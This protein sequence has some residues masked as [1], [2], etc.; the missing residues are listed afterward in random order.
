MDPCERII[1]EALTSGDHTVGLRRVTCNAAVVQQISCTCG[2]ILDQHT[3]VVIETPDERV[4]AA[5]CPDCRRQAKRLW[6]GHTA[7]TWDSS[8]PL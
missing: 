1:A 3:V 2:N 8:E 6:P 5:Y 7:V 4:V